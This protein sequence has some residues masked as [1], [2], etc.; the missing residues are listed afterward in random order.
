MKNELTFLEGVCIVSGCSI[1]SGIMAIPFFF[2]GVGLIPSILIL[3][4]AYVANVLL[5]IMFAEMIIN[6]EEKGNLIS[7]IVKYF[8]SKNTNMFA[9]FYLLLISLGMVA[10]LSSYICGASEIIVSLLGLEKP[11][12]QLITYL[13]CALLVL[14]GLKIV[15]LSEKYTMWGIIAI[16]AVLLII[17]LLNNNMPIPLLGKDLSLSLGLYGISM[18]SFGALFS[19]PQVVEGFQ[20]KK[21]KVGFA[22]TLG[23]LFNLIIT[24]II[25]LCVI[26]TSQEVTMVGVIG[27]SKTLGPW[28]IIPSSL[29]VIFSLIT[30]Y[31]SVSLAL[32]DIVKANFKLSN[33]LCWVIS[34]LPSFLLAYIAEKGYSSYM[35]MAGGIVAITTSLLYIPSYYKFIKAG[36]KPILLKNIGRSNWLIIVVSIFYIFMAISAFINS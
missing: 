7:V 10:I 9:G 34:T 11:F 14:F 21:K 19:V 17:S 20:H 33:N 28:I 3:V 15:G 1:G 30:S 6:S 31:W 25:A 2:N 13:S 26:I 16:T 27:W 22:I 18:F 29:F 32:S 24:I 12:P 4:A 5:H 36:G 35:M 23:L 8:F